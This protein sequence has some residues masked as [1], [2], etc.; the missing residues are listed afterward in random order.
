MQVQYCDL[1]GTPMKDYNYY[2]LYV[3]NPGLSIPNINNFDDEK[4][5]Y[6][7]YYK[8]VMSVQGE[9]KEICSGCKCIFDKI[10]ELR[11]QRLSELTDSIYRE[12]Q[13]PSRPNPDERKNNEKKK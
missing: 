9:T 5:Y 8:Y 2:L 3:H 6:R 13:L 1:C 4:E 11:L 10:F 12:F 7:A